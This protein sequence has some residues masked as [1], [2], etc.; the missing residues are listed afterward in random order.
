[1]IHRNSNPPHRQKQAYPIRD[2]LVF[3]CEGDLK[4][5]CNVDKR[6][7]RGLDR[8]AQLSIPREIEHRDR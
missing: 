6:C 8:A 7:R 1:M 5:K 4:I 3:A 2:M